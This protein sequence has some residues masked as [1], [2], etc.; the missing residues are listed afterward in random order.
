[1]LSS[2]SASFPWFFFISLTWAAVCH[3]LEH[4]LRAQE[5]KGN[6]VWPVCICGFLLCSHQPHSA[7]QCS[8]ST[9]LTHTH[10]GQTQFLRPL[11]F[12]MYVLLIMA[13]SC[14]WSQ[15]MPPFILD[16]WGF[17]TSVGKNKTRIWGLLSLVQTKPYYCIIWFQYDGGNIDTEQ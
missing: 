11:L 2:L 9:Q 12:P 1:M 8:P 6:W 10:T 17:R 15:M 4:I 14:S 5:R 7:P 3:D 13:H 16:H